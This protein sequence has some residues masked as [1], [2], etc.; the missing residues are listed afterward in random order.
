MPPGVTMILPNTADTKT[1]IEETEA[2]ITIG[3]IKNFY[4][5]VSSV[6]LILKL[7]IPILNLTINN[8]IS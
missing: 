8:K 7:H 2:Q 5:E 6:L 1:K 3:L 4:G